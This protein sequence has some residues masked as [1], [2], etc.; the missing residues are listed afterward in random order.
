MSIFDVMRSIPIDDSSMSVLAMLV[1]IAGG[2]TL[3]SLHQQ[4]KAKRVKLDS[5]RRMRDFG[6]GQ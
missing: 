2:W 3:T 1:G 5:Q 6:K 4:L